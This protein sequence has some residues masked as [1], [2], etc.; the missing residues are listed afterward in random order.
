MDQSSISYELV[1]ERT[2]TD[3]VLRR[4]EQKKLVERQVNPNDKRSRQVY[5]TTYG[6]E[7]MKRLAPHMN[8]AQERLLAPLV[9]EEKERFMEL[10][11][12]VVEGNNESGRTILR[13]L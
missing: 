11:T 13:T 12:K 3:D 7:L 4:L 2:T 10:L 6:I 8:S 9:P 1:I 5:I